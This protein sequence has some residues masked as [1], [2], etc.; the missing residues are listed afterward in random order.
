MSVTTTLASARPA[1]VLG[2]E[3]PP[4]GARLRPPRAQSVGNTVPGWR[5]PSRVCALIVGAGVIVALGVRALVPQLG[6]VGD[7]LRALG[8]VSL[9]WLV[10]LIAISA[11]SFPGAALSLQGASPERLP[12]R[13]T[14]AVNVA[15]AFTGRLAPASL[16]SMGTVVLFLHRRGLSGVQAATTVGVDAAAGVVVHV[17]LLGATASAMGVAVPGR[18]GG[19]ELAWAAVLVAT[20]V[21]GAGLLSRLAP[22]RPRWLAAA[23]RSVQTAVQSLASAVRSPRRAALLLSGSLLVSLSQVA[24]LALALV[25]AG[26]S[27]PALTVAVAYLAASALA[28]VAPTPG[29]LGAMEAA[30]VG[31]LTLLGT[32]A[33]PALAGVLIFRLLTFWLPLVPGAVA[34][35]RL[36]RRRV[37]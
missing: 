34:L 35:A 15:A 27:T 25:A 2:T 12:F 22:R 13:K 3:L 16:G 26:G 19:R 9:W 24:V 4:L 31:A 33:G 5:R 28:S 29:G 32:A 23:V 11:L 20:L 6:G 14:L 8:Q 18:T 37:L 36:R 21:G 17:L 10:P 30:L 7:S 1:A